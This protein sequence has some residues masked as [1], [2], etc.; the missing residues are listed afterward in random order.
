M[1]WQKTSITSIAILL[2]IFLFSSCNLLEQKKF[3][4]LNKVPANP[5]L[6]EH[7]KDFPSST[8]IKENEKSELVPVDNADSNI[9]NKEKSESKTFKKDFKKRA[10]KTIRNLLFP[11]FTMLKAKISAPDDSKESVIWVTLLALAIM[12]LIILIHV[13]TKTKLGCWSTIIVFFCI[14]F[15]IFGLVY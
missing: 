7:Q 2:L 13:I 14:A 11:D 15:M 1:F 5:V 9:Y 12:V 3:A 10:E 8:D 6:V 4:Y